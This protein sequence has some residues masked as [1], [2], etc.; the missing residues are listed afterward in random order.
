MIGR[1]LCGEVEFEIVGMVPNLYQCHCSQ[2]R[3][4]SGSS[5]NSATLVTTKQFLWRAGENLIT[6]F[7]ERSGFNSHFCSLCGS[8]VPNQLAGG[9]FIWIPAGALE[10]SKD[11]EV[12]AHLFVE[13]KASWEQICNTGRLYD[14]MPSL[15]EL[16]HLLQPKEHSVPD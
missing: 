13:S 8:P 9:E 3:K 12:V 6:R 4:Q 15:A 1:C 10:T 5:S 7:K 14:A 16:Q 11:L 2:C